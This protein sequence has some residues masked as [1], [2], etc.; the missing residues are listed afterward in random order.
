MKKI[1]LILLLCFSF[2][3][4]YIDECKSDVYFANGI[5]TNE[6]TAKRS[7]DEIEAEYKIKY[8]QKYSTIKKWDTVYNHTHGIGIDLYESMLQKIYEDEVGHSFLPFL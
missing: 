5:D 8:P 3:D 4:A 7:V 6:K 2:L 1:F